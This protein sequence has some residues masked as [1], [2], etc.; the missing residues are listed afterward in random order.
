[1]LENIF[2]YTIQQ[3]MLLSQYVREYFY[4]AGNTQDIFFV[5]FIW[6]LCILFMFFERF[7]E[8]LPNW[9][10]MVHIFKIVHPLCILYS[11]SNSNCSIAIYVCKQY[12][13]DLFEWY[14]A[15][16]AQLKAKLSK[17]QIYNTYVNYDKRWRLT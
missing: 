17:L 5:I 1:M 16:M 15:T 6:I 14:N 2:H 12:N 13:E 3:S 9:F 7:K 8:K 11:T 4:S 10:N